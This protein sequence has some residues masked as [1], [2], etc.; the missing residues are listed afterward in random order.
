MKKIA[1]T[2]LG[3][4]YNRLESAELAHEL[5]QAGYAQAAEGEGPADVVVI[6]TC[7]V[8]SKSAASAR[9]AIRAARSGHPGARVVVTGCYSETSPA[10]VA[11]VEGVDLVLGNTEKFSMAAALKRLED[12][13]GQGAL[14]LAD[15]GPMP[16]T[17][18][19]RPVT[20]M[21]GR[22]NAYLN[23]QSG[24]DDLCS[25]CV[26]RLARGKSRSAPAAELVEQVKRLADS[27]IREVVLSGIN[28]G[29]YQDGAMDLATLAEAIL[30]ETDIPRLRF[31][32]IN[33]N[34]VSQGLIDLMAS[35]PRFCPHLHIPLQNGSDRILK[36]MRRP[37]TSAMYEDL[38]NRLAERVPG[39]GLGAD[40]MTGFP[41]ETQEDFE[42]T[43]SLIERLPLMMLH[44][45]SYSRRAGTEAY[46]LPGAVA[47]VDA[48]ERTA[49]L[50]ELS[51]K[52]RQ[53]FIKDHVGKEMVALAQNRRPANGKL[54]GFTAYYIPAVFDGPDSMLNTM[55]R[56]VG[57]R[58][59]DGALYCRVAEEA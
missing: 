10:D 35:E 51:A 6:N 24:C 59:E 4:R 55:V 32:S 47:K 18:A 28:I 30:L 2:T 36:L 14:V 39:I 45:F 33:P 46:S 17:L 53:M 19:V 26:V 9:A 41:G 42:R 31:S 54:R 57:L 16:S 13:P 50:M 21:S 23:V 29:Q 58:E 12:N 15:H 44:V 11:S 8:T 52:K 25:F 7:A 5:G 20:G 34:N 22:T 48:K 1:F 38:L 40:V 3:C 43:R 56:V 27:G 49:R 37:Y